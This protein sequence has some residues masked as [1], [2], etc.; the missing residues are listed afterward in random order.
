MAFCTPA[1]RMVELKRW[2]FAY[3]FC[4]VRNED[5]T[6]HFAYVLSYD[7]RYNNGD[8]WCRRLWC[9]EKRVFFSRIWLTFI[10]AECRLY[11]NAIIYWFCNSDCDFAIGWL[12]GA[13]YLG[14]WS[15]YISI[16]S[17]VG[18]VQCWFLIVIH[19]RK[20]NIFINRR[21]TKNE[22][23]RINSPV[24][25]LSMY[26]QRYITGSFRIG[27]PQLNFTCLTVNCVMKI[28]CKRDM[29]F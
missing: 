13:G 11:A 21:K 5:I 10:V 8:S 4:Y 17:T 2:I 28:K 26:G 22:R 27:N 24:K 6:L 14:N 15:I 29:N 12:V 25:W 7:S 19:V 18:C 20:K 16:E 23:K 1:F 9:G 3:N